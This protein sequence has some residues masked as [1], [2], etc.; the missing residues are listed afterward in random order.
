MAT[1][2]RDNLLIGQYEFDSIERVKTRYGYQFFL[3]KWKRA[4][5][6][7][8]PRI[9]ST[10]SGIQQDTAELDETVDLLDDCDGPDIRED[11]GHSFLLTDENIELVGTAFPEEVERFWQE[12]VFIISLI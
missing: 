9:P 4:M 3:V 7:I 6:N 1:T 2:T 5:A 11:D 12:Q 8:A 10:K